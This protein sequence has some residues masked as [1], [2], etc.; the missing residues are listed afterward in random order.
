M[1]PDYRDEMIAWLLFQIE[2]SNAIVQVSTNE[3]LIDSLHWINLKHI[4]QVFSDPLI[5]NLQIEWLIFEILLAQCLSTQ[6]DDHIAH[7]PI[8]VWVLLP[9][10]N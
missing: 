3:K 5:P 2:N 1:V 9:H 8:L 10:E 7:F 4:I 6:V